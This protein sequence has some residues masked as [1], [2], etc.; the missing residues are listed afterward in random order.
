MGENVELKAELDAMN[1]RMEVMSALGKFRPE[2]LLTVSQTNADLAASIQALL[3]KL[4][5]T[6]KGAPPG[7]A[8]APA[9]ASSSIDGGLSGLLEP[10]AMA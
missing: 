6:A 2:D 3:P 5:K 8:R 7:A 4:D 10:T 9:A 1:E